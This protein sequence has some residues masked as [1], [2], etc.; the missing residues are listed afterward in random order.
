MVVASLRAAGLPV[1]VTPLRATADRIE[2]TGETGD[3]GRQA[4]RA[5][6]SLA[7]EEA[8]RASG[9]MRGWWVLRAERAERA[10][11][12]DV[13]WVTGA[14][15]TLALALEGPPAETPAPEPSSD[16]PEEWDSIVPGSVR[17]ALVGAESVDWA[18]DSLVGE[19]WRLAG[20][21]RESARAWVVWGF[22]RSAAM[23][24]RCVTVHDPDEAAEWV[25][26]GFSP[27]TVVA[28]RDAGFAPPEA[29][30][31]AAAGF[32]SELAA[33]TRDDADAREIVGELLSAVHPEATGAPLLR[34]GPEALQAGL[35]LVA[36]RFRRAGRIGEATAALGRLVGSLC[37][38]GRASEAAVVLAALPD[39]SRVL[40]SRVALAGGLAA[41]VE[42]AL[43][44]LSTESGAE[45][46]LLRGVATLRRGDVRAALQHFRGAQYRAEESHEL[47]VFALARYHT[48]H[49]LGHPEARVFSGAAEAATVALADGV[50]LLSASD[51][52]RDL[53]A[54][55]LALARLSLRR[56]DREATA[57][58]DVAI[59]HLHAAL[60]ALTAAH[61]PEH[62]GQAHLL[63]GTVLQE[64]STLGRGETLAEA[65]AHL[66][67][68]L[69]L[70]R[71]PSEREEARRAL[72]AATEA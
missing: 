32:D 57:R 16:D 65:R 30:E 35:T 2:A 23:A 53:G 11:T 18:P 47:R 22:A 29:A 42:H 14:L 26:H 7:R 25:A 40:Q 68:A 19:E 71:D 44:L 5:L 43:A 67:A 4:A 24:W 27:A 9:G 39:P 52:P 49:A 36:E 48:G 62:R 55:H 1:V 8:A 46:E 21:G 33:A 15:R 28:W 13:S 37:A 34:A 72:D 56:R 54:A 66:R 61:A 31:L 3:A 63:L 58:Q 50:R 60:A 70:L 38:R 64:R 17:W 10:P 59:E 69:R 6:A 41:G 45:A 20:L 51:A 12:S